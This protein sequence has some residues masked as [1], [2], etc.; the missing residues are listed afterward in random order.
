M[1]HCRVNEQPA[2]REIVLEFNRNHRKLGSCRQ[3]YLGKSERKFLHNRT[4]EKGNRFPKYTAGINSA[5]GGY[6]SCDDYD[7]RNP[8][9]TLA[10]PSAR[11]IIEPNH[12]SNQVTITRNKHHQE[13]QEHQND[14]PKRLKYQQHVRF[15]DE[16]YLSD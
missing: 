15:S 7:F 16:K 10:T 2:V 5:A 6:C 12:K 11:N 14:R 13:H 9:S 1:I 4:T 3:P 8:A